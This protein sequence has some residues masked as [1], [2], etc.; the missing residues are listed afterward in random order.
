[1]AYMTIFRPKKK[2]SNNNG[3][4]APRVTQPTIQRWGGKPSAID[5]RA[6]YCVRLMAEKFQPEYLFADG[7][8]PV[9]FERIRYWPETKEFVCVY[10]TEVYCT[11]TFRRW[12]ER[13]IWADRRRG[14]EELKQFGVP[15]GWR[16][17]R[18]AWK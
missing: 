17:W 4:Q 11:Q 15:T 2:W 12:T 3:P 8:R 14:A 7:F 10:R 16:Q 13:Y 6:P 9:H 5:A 1:M 18:K